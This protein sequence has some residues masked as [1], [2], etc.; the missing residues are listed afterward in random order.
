MH[1]HRKMISKKTRRDIAGALLLGGKH[2]LYEPTG[3]LDAMT[4]LENSKR[5]KVLATVVAGS[6]VAL[7]AGTAFAQP[8]PGFGW[9]YGP[10]FHGYYSGQEVARD[11]VEA[12]VKAALAKATKG[13]VWTSPRGDK[14]TPIMVDNEVVGNLFE[15]SDLT[16]LEVGSYWAGAFGQQI[17]LLSGSRVV[18]MM[19][20]RA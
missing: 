2:C 19:W 5:S 3:G 12:A 9:R 17:E 20:V 16:T 4:K 14:H 8:G 6:L 13:T 10:G 18:G 7:L 11:K 15:D 1:F